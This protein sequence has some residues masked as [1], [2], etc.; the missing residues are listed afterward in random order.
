MFYE[1][2][3]TT[4]QQHFFNKLKSMH[5]LTEV[6]AGKMISSHGTGGLVFYKALARIVVE[7]GSVSA[8]A[9]L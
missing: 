2:K 9:P 5:S 1:W 4:K 3:S 8:S 6:I 7:I